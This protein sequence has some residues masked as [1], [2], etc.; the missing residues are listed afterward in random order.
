MKKNLWASKAKFGLFPALG[1][2]CAAAWTDK[3][4]SALVIPQK[5]KATAFK[6]LQEY[7]PP[8][9]IGFWDKPLSPVPSGIRIQAQR[10]LKGKPYRFKSFDI[11]FLTSFQQRILN[12]TCQ[13]PYGQTRTYGWVARKAESP[14]AFRAAGQALNRNPVAVFIPCHRVV[15]G[16]KK[17]GG[18]GGGIDWKIRLLEKEGVTVNQGRLS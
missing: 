1:G 2:W 9:P 18:Y 7:L 17:L 16:E 4:L 8:A 11:S 13:I 5:V 14:R 15:A 12:A 3:G 6:K 10:A